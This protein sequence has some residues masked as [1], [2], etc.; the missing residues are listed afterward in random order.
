MTPL[1]PI[2]LVDQI[3]DGRPIVLKHFRVPIS[4]ISNN[5]IY[6]VIA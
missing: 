6:G 5:M 3:A 4:Q 1:M 2:R